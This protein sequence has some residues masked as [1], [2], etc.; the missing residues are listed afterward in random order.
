MLSQFLISEVFA[1][2]LIFS[3]VGAAIMLLPGFG[4][5]YIPVRGRLF[6]ALM[7]SLMLVPVTAAIP[8]VPATVAGL[9]VLL[10]AEI[11]VGLFIGGLSRIL[12]STLHITG[13]MIA[14]QSSLVSALVPSITQVQ[15]QESAVGNFL[16]VAAVTLIFAT[17]LHHLMLKALAD[18]YMLFLPGQFPIVSDMADTVAKT[19]SGTFRMAMQLAAPHMVTGLML[20]MG[21]GIISRLMPNIQIFF[22]MMPAQLLLSFFILMLVVSAMLMWYLDYFKTTLEM[23]LAP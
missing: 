15:T 20:Y 4:E 17:D 22:I 23:F 14:Y 6:L 9:V 3:R 8:P 18:S 19:V 2:L 16:S 7:F 12:I 13:M 5:I 1:F 21:S 10:A 11:M